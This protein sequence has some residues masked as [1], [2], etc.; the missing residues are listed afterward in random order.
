MAA[1]FSQA[2]TAGDRSG[3]VTRAAVVLADPLPERCFT[4]GSGRPTVVFT[5]ERYL[6][7][8]HA[9]RCPYRFA[10]NRSGV[11][12]LSFPDGSLQVRLKLPYVA[13]R[14]RHLSLL[15]LSLRFAGRVDRTARNAL[16]RRGS[17]NVPRFGE[18][19]AR[20]SAFSPS[21][22]IHVS[23]DSCGRSWVLRRLPQVQ[24]RCVVCSRAAFVIRHRRRG[25]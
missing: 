16:M 10:G 14:R 24:W 8:V 23:H 12:C 6:P 13:V 2:S 1:W 17:S 22:M 5:A 20:A 3:F 19:G 11:L 21:L 4:G 25:R 9:S 7:C 18:N 15:A